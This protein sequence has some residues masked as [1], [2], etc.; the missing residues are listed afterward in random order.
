LARVDKWAVNIPSPDICSYARSTLRNPIKSQR[1]SEKLPSPESEKVMKNCC[2]AFLFFAALAG[3]KTIDLKNQGI[4]TLTVEQVNEDSD[5]YDGKTVVVRG[6]IAT[7]VHPWEMKMYDK[8]GILAG[9]ETAWLTIKSEFLREDG[10]K[11]LVV[12][13]SV[14]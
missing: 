5:L 1:S 10:P 7:K 8:R 3:C 9:I 14:V 4:V 13:P 2:H 6:R 11:E 12:S